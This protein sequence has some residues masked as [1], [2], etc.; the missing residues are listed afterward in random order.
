MQGGDLIATASAWATNVKWGA[1]TDADDELVT[2]GESCSGTECGVGGSGWSSWGASCS[3]T[4]CDTIV[5][6]SEQS[7][8]I[9]WGDTCGGEDCETVWATS[10]D[11]IVV[12]GNSDDDIVVWG[13]SDDD[14]VV[15]GNS[16]DDIVVWGNSG[17]DPDSGPVIWPE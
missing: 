12:W 5:W 14:I 6:G 15:W 7:V 4:N 3:G 17:E 16:D 2:W 13:N 8:N 1:A 11:D 9:V 10:D